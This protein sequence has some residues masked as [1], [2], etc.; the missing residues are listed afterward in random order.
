MPRSAA[1]SDGKRGAL[2]G[3]FAAALFGVSAP[4]SKLLLG[5]ISAQLLAGLLYLGAGLAL[6]GYGFLQRERREA[7]LRS[8]DL[9]LLTGIVVCGGVLGPLFMLLGL[10]RV[11]AVTGSLLLNLEAPLTMLLAV[12]LFREHLGRRAALA[13]GMIVLG[14]ALLKL[15]FGTVTVDAGGVLLI[16]LGCACWGLDNNLTQ[17]LSTRDPWSIVRVKTLAAGSVNLVLGLCWGGK[18]PGLAPLGAALL[19]GSLSYGLSVV[20]DAYALRF[21][22]AAR[23]AAYFATAPFLGALLSAPLLGDRL[24]WLDGAAMFTM[25]IG[26]VL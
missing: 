25:G 4:L 13:A 23:E 9:P 17:R 11:S 21:V 12:L 2:C 14:A 6:S 24:R 8:S 20:L 26:V 18:L 22:G 1:L 19:L 10:T 15:E 3:L 7:A 5:S 16:A